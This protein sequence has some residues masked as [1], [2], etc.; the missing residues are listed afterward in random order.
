MRLS[1][2]IP[3]RAIE[4]ANLVLESMIKV[5]NDR[6][7]LKSRRKYYGVRQK[8]LNGLDNDDVGWVLA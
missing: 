3:R 8:Q 5:D 6:L 7:L 1:E 2:S 4:A